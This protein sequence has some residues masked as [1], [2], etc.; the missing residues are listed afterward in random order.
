MR[1]SP[2]PEP[3]TIV[4]VLVD[5]MAIDDWR[6]RTVYGF[7]TLVTLLRGE[8]IYANSYVIFDDGGNPPTEIFGDYVEDGLSYDIEGIGTFRV[9]I[10]ETLVFTVIHEE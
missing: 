5:S 8:W 3:S 7:S 6:G 10:E 9:Y 4:G 2:A 1:P